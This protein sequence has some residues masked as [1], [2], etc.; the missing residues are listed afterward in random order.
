MSGQLPDPEAANPRLGQVECVSDLLPR[1]LEAVTLHVLNSSRGSVCPEIPITPRHINH[2]GPGRAVHVP[3]RRHFVFVWAL[4]SFAANTRN[5]DSKGKRKSGC[6]PHIFQNQ[7]HRVVHRNSPPGSH[8]FFRDH[9]C[10]KHKTVSTFRL[11][12]LRCQA[13]CI[14]R[15][16]RPPAIRE[17]YRRLR[18]A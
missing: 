15:H 16:Q 6:A 1:F 11:R 2:D 7:I 9:D 13:E 10:P 12:H 14:A 4:F 18:Q 3:G 8:D 17:A 5:P